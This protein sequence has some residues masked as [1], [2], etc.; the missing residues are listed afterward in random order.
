M[1]G[2]HTHR[3]LEGTIHLSAFLPS[4]DR[5]LGTYYRGRRGASDYCRPIRVVSGFY[6]RGLAGV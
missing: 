2:Y 4:L 3:I 1:G 5:P 6:E